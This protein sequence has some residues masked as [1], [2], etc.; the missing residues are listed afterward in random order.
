[1]PYHEPFIHSHVCNEPNASLQ[2]TESSF[3]LGDC[4]RVAEHPV[5]V[6]LA[7]TKAERRPN[8][9]PLGA[10]TCQGTEWFL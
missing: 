4:A 2:G 3:A 6:R 9:P 5:D 7:T 1:M 10:G 8:T